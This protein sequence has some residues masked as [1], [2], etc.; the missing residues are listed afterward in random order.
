MT[1]FVTA[2]SFPEHLH[3]KIRAMIFHYPYIL[4]LLIAR[5]STRAESLR[6]IIFFKTIGVMIVVAITTITIGG[7]I[8][9]SIRP[10]A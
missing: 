9:A 4:S 7:N 2:C 3:K 6:Y 5:F 8:F 1:A 10:I